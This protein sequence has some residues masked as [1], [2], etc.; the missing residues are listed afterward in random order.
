[1]LRCQIILALSHVMYLF[2]AR[3]FRSKDLSLYHVVVV[4]QASLADRRCAGKRSCC[5]L[6]RDMEA[7]NMFHHGILNTRNPAA[8]Q[9]S[10]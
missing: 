4:F 2:N 7:A 9:R 1:M 5:E 8:C 3:K 10:T 6:A